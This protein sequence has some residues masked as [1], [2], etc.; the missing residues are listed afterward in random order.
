MKQNIPL[1]D[2]TGLKM[3]L[4][5]KKQEDAINTSLLAIKKSLNEIDVKIK[6][7]E[8]RVKRLERS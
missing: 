1:I 6:S 2:F 4:Q 5:N 7:L 3:G 8:E